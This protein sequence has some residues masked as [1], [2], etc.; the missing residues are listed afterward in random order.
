MIQ[1]IR[2]YSEIYFQKLNCFY[3]CSKVSSCIFTPFSIYPFK[4]HSCSFPFSAIFFLKSWI[5]SMDTSKNCVFNLNFTLLLLN[6]VPPFQNLLCKLYLHLQSITTKMLNNK[7]TRF[8]V[9]H[10]NFRFTLIT[11]TMCCILY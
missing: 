4:T 3:T 9:T 1:T 6:F 8:V 7:I 2:Y 5:L 10:T 11:P